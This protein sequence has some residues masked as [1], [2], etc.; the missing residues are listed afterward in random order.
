MSFFNSE[1]SIVA[2]SKKKG[3]FVGDPRNGLEGCAM[4]RWLGGE[5]GGMCGHQPSAPGQRSCVIERG[6]NN[7]VSKE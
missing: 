3:S 6:S 2:I 1:A 7:G 5:R 4:G